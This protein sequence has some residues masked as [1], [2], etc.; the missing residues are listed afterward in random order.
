MKKAEAKPRAR[1]S[2]LEK[3][4]E[5]FTVPSKKVPE[6]TAIAPKFFPINYST[7]QDT[8]HVRFGI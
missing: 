4:A 2:L 8:K 6:V 1:M 5:S 7:V 3:V